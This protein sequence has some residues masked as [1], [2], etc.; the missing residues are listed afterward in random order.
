MAVVLLLHNL[1]FSSEIIFKISDSIDL[2]G[3]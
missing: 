1:I 3:R 2:Q